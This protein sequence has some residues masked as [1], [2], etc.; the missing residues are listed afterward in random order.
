MPRLR[1]AVPLALAALGAT[2]TACSSTDRATP[3]ASATAAVEAPKPTTPD[4]ILRA[5]LASAL[6]KGR[7]RASLEHE[8]R[9]PE[10]PGDVFGQGGLGLS[11]LGESGGR[12]EGIGLG[13]IGT[14][15]GTGRLGSG[16]R[17]KP[18][19]VRPG[20][21]NVSGRLPPEVIQRIVRRNFGRL[22]QCY[23]NALRT[24][25]SVSGRI[26]VRFVIGR[27]GSVS[28]VSHTSD[29]A[30]PAFTS[31]ITR[32]FQGLSFPE[33]E[34]GIVTVSYPIVFTPSDGPPA[35]SA[36]A[37]AS[38]SAAPEASSAPAPADTA[39]ASAPPP[40]APPAPT[41]TLDPAAAP[42]SDPPAPIV[43]LEGA[44]VLLDGKA[45]GTTRAIT[46]ADKVQKVDEL[47]AGL[48]AV[49][50]A[51][52]SAHPDSV[53]PGVCGLRVAADV[54][55]VALKRVFQT[56]ALA[57]YPTIL[58]Q[59]AW[60][61]EVVTTLAAPIPGP[62]LDEE[63]LARLPAVL[64]ARLAEGE[65][66]LEWRRGSVVASTSKASASEPELGKKLCEEWQRLGSHKDATDPLRDEL[67][68]HA[69]DTSSYSALLP[70]IAATESCTRP[71]PGGGTMPAWLLALSVR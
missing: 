21:S 35:A 6:A 56:I 2:A 15:S 58:V 5:G 48:G 51:W 24:D 27:D 60:S 30:D 36:S 34:G 43:V 16:H 49:R 61:P 33:P 62:P 42:G 8:E 67:V 12:P 29:I 31:C 71:A 57:G 66:T 39:T 63:A 53:F 26:T 59:P 18:P 52:K 54:P 46:D 50:E 41:G 4:E 13:S 22:R 45:A 47:F 17:A 25:P 1:I 55:L 14:R 20:A 23:E 9:A 70:V 68:L 32:Q 65:L 28:S 37:S 38:A 3:A 19:Q 69:A 7:Q 11:G 44:S 40:E 10:Q 64:H